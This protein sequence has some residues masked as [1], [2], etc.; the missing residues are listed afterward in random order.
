MLLYNQCSKQLMM[1]EQDLM[2]FQDQMS[3]YVIAIL[4]SQLLHRFFLYDFVCPFV[5]M[6]CSGS[7]SRKSWGTEVLNLLSIY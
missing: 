5:L 6:V 7:L 4:C 3:L 2:E 1:M